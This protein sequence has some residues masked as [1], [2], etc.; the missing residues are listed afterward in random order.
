M[1]KNRD[2]EYFDEEQ[3]LREQ[4]GELT[5]DL[6]L[7]GWAWTRLYN[8][9]ESKF[10]LPSSQRKEV[11]RFIKECYIAELRSR[12]DVVTKENDKRQIELDR[13]DRLLLAMDE[14]VQSGD[15]KAITTALKIVQARVEVLGL[16]AAKQLEITS[17]VKDPADI[18]IDRLIAEANAEFELEDD[19][20]NP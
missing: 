15:V 7:A 4:I 8:F 9:I 3:T 13:L 1:G 6:K 20:D 18:E 5:Y 2:L 19:G 11:R 16:K 14:R 17:V 12:R 10:N